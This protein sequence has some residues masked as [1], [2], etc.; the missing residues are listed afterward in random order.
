MLYK[1]LKELNNCGEILSLTIYKDW[2]LSAHCYKVKKLIIKI[3]V[4]EQSIFKSVMKIIVN[5]FDKL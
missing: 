1:V 5:I 4:K 2:N 3:F